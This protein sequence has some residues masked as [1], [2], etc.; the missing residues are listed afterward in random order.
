[1]YIIV[2]QTSRL[3][4]SVQSVQIAVSISPVV[5]GQLVDLGLRSYGE[6]IDILSY[7]GFISMVRSLFVHREQ[8]ARYSELYSSK[9]TFR[10]DGEFVLARGQ[11]K[12]QHVHPRVDSIC[13]QTPLIG[14]TNQNKHHALN[15]WQ[16]F[17]LWSMS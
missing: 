3:L 15:M 7:I 12:L 13:R 4:S 16:V 9:V 10:G 11:F 8:L 5:G 1:M 6:H 17:I 14:E 2:H